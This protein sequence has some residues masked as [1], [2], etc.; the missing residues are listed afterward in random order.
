MHVPPT[1]AA[2]AQ[3]FANNNS[4][5]A[6]APVPATSRGV[7]ASVP[8][9]ERRHTHCELDARSLQQPSMPCSEEETPKNKCFRGVKGTAARTQP[10]AHPK[11]PVSRASAIL[12]WKPESVPT[13]VPCVLLIVP[14]S[15]QQTCPWSRCCRTSVKTRASSDRNTSLVPFLSPGEHRL[16]CPLPDLLSHRCQLRLLGAPLLGRHELEVIP[17][18]QNHDHA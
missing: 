15:R 7:N 14:L 2:R 9:P 8:F 18:A 1:S 3:G 5:G 4:K 11:E 10:M 6:W 17:H 12:G 16:A 13:R